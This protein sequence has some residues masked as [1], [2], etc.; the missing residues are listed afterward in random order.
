MNGL[1]YVDLY[2]KYLFL[3]CIQFIDFILDVVLIVNRLIPFEDLAFLRSNL[4]RVLL[5]RFRRL[6]IVVDNLII[7]DVF[8]DVFFSLFF[9]F[10]I[11][12][13]WFYLYLMGVIYKTHIYI[14]EI[15]FIVGV[16]N[17]ILYIDMKCQ[18]IGSLL[19][20]IFILPLSVCCVVLVLLSTRFLSVET[21]FY[22]A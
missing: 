10:V 17:A 22:F 21:C 19:Y 1:I 5:S 2:F 6:H 4:I 14:L 18:V 11:L 15:L 12:V 3:Y 9:V 8:D 20:S 7:L 13:F 16:S